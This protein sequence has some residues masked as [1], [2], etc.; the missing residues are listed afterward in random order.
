MFAH[1][2]HIQISGS[3][4]FSRVLETIDN[5]FI[6]ITVTIIVQSFIK[7]LQGGPTPV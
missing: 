7:H 1:C 2:D 6:S 3:Q 4:D 5:R